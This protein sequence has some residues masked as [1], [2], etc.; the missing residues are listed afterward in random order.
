[1][2]IA[3]VIAEEAIEYLDG[4]IIRIGAKNVPLPYS[5]ELENHVLPGTDDIV[6]AAKRLCGK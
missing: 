1:A 5:P 4:P 6:D 2:E 3:A